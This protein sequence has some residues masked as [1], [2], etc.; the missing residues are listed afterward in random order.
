MV[1]IKKSDEGKAWARRR[2][3]RSRP[4]A[5][6]IRKRILIVS[7]DEK[8]S[9]YY[10]R[11][12]AEKFLLG[13]VSVCVCGKGMSTKSLVEEVPRVESEQ[14]G[15]LRKS[16]V[17]N[18]RFDEIW[19]VFDLDAF[20]GEDFDNAILMAEAMPHCHVAWSNECFEY[21]YLLHFNK[22]AA[23]M[24]R[25]MIYDKLESQIP[26]FHARFPNA[27]YEDLKGEA[28]RKIHEE[29]ALMESEREQAIKWAAA[30]DEYWSSGNEASHNRN[31]ATKVYQLIRSLEQTRSIGGLRT[32]GDARIG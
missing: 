29:F 28:G 12:Y 31:P 27:H 3:S 19:V 9:C 26:S 25:T 4:A 18:P 10:F 1:R 32:I 7:E 6:E 30:Q 5:V 13:Y 24:K 21:W 23:G 14:L 16:G 11:K 22:Y 20:E 15:L 17:V 2:M 8:S